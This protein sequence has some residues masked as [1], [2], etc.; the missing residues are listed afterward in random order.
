MMAVKAADVAAVGYGY[1]QGYNRPMEI[2]SLQVSHKSFN[3]IIVDLY[4]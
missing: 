2:I 3:R 1:A 4:N